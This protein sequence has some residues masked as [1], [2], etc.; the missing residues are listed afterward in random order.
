[1]GIFKELVDQHK[2]NA[3]TEGQKDGRTV[4]DGKGRKVTDRDGNWRKW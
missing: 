3:R 1:M 2:V 4:K